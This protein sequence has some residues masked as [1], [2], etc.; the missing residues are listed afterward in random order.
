LALLNAIRAVTTVAPDLAAIERA[1]ARYLRYQVVEQGVVPAG[2]A[3]MWQAPAMAG[4]PYLTLVPENGAACWLRFVEHPCARGFKALTS[5]GWAATEILVQDPDALAAAFADGGPFEVIGPPA[6]L[7]R[8]PMIRAM[9][10]LGPAGECLYFTRVGDGSGLALPQARCFVDRVFIVVAAGP[11]IDPLMDHYAAYGN[12]IDPPVKTP[13]KVI[14]RA[15]GLPE[16]TLHAHGLIKLSDGT[17]IELD[18]YPPQCGPRACVEGVLP[19]G[20]AMVTF[21]VDTEAPA[22]AMPT[23]LPGRPAAWS[24]IGPAGE[25]LEFVSAR[26]G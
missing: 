8:F 1:Y 24:R 23:L 10:V 2:V 4:Q 16:D 21:A 25:R 26:H 20:M 22:D 3:Q 15:N 5:H 19:P 9:Q 7:T 17:L 18:E 11:R 12:A 13:V 6:S 14:S